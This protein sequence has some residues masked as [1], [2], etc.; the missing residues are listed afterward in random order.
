MSPAGAPWRPGA[1]HAGLSSPAPSRVGEA[2]IIE[3]RRRPATGG[4]AVKPTAAAIIRGGGLSS[5]VPAGNR[6]H[7]YLES[8]SLR[9]RTSCIAPR[10][11]SAGNQPALDNGRTREMASPLIA[12]ELRPKTWC[13]LARMTQLSEQPSTGRRNHGWYRTGATSSAATPPVNRRR[14]SRHRIGSTSIIDGVVEAYSRD[15]SRRADAAAGDAP[16]YVAGARL[17]EA[18]TAPGKV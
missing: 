15:H 5:A 11:P 7:Q 17:T 10:K 8:E 9:R 12:P 6:R 2:R 3:M 13:R 14:A 4:W 16:E 18:V 1:R